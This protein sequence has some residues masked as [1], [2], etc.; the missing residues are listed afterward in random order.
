MNVRVQCL[1]FSFKLAYFDMQ[2]SPMTIVLIRTHLHMPELSKWD[3]ED[4][5][6]SLDPDF[7][8]PSLPYSQPY[9]VTT[10]KDL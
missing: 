2:L 8:E 7:Q 3:H 1:P 5:A 9:P 6:Q 10:S 4:D